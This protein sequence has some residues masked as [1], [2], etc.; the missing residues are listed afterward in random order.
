MQNNNSHRYWWWNKWRTTDAVAYYDQFE[1]QD[2]IVTLYD[3]KW[4]V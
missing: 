1:K 4:Y 3:P 2:W